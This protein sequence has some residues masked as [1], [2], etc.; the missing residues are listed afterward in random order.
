MSVSEDMRPQTLAHGTPVASGQQSHTSIMMASHHEF[1]LHNSSDTNVRHHLCLTSPCTFN[2]CPNVCIPTRCRARAEDRPYTGLLRGMSWNP[3]AFFACDGWKIA[4]RIKIVNDLAQQHDFFGLQ[5]THSCPG[6]AAAVQ[7]A[8]QQHTFLLV[9]WDVPKRRFSTRCVGPVPW[10][11]L[12]RR[13]ER[14]RGG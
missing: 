8:F 2:I 3:R 10:K 6:R 14:N 7:Q 4:R 13:M 11:F 1:D 5:E 12:P 9:P